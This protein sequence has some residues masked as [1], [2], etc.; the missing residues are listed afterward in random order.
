MAEGT[1]MMGMGRIKICFLDCHHIN[2]RRLSQG[3]SVRNLIYLISISE[4]ALWSYGNTTAVMQRAF[5]T[6]FLLRPVYNYNQNGD[7]RI[8]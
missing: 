6:L 8:E 2:A 3:T 7:Q 1:E 5:Q 4:N